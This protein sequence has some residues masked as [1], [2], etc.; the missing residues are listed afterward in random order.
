MLRIDR[1]LS[2]GLED[3]E[4][5]RFEEISDSNTASRI[6]RFKERSDNSV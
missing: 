5:G 3:I 6:A 2:E 4:H 1:G